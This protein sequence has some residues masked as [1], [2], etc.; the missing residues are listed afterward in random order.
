[1]NEEQ[2]KKWGVIKVL[3]F[4]PWAK[5]HFMN[6]VP[7]SVKKITVLDKTNEEGSAGN[8]LF[9]DVLGTTTIYR[10]EIK[11]VGGAY[12]ISSKNFDPN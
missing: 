8:P 12:A 6:K 5:E 4:R 3:L 10:P 1:M 11:V 9:L 7:K 2:G